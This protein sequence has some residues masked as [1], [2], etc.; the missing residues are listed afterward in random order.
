[1]TA[2]NTARRRRSGKASRGVRLVGG[3]RHGR[4]DNDDD[5][6]A[7]PRDRRR[8]VGEGGGGRVS[9]DALRMQR[10]RPLVVSV[11]AVVTCGIHVGRCR[12]VDRL[13]ELSFVPPH[14]HKHQFHF[15]KIIIKMFCS[16]KIREN[17]FYEIPIGHINFI[18]LQ[19]NEIQPSFSP[20]F[21]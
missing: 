19:F 16:R 8:H 9:S 17:N 7:R 12:A 4:C 18:W 2:A 3:H 14:S 1:M 15:R 10:R 20:H 5:S 13:V 6:T 11:H 21:L